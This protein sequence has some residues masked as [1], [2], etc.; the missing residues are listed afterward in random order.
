M[1]TG[2]P[3]CR[4]PRRLQ[5]LSSRSGCRK[6]TCDQDTETRN[7]NGQGHSKHEPLVTSS[8][9]H[10][11]STRQRHILTMPAACRVPRTL[12]P[13]RSRSGCIEDSCAPH[14][15]HTH[16][17]RGRHSITHTPK[18]S[19][20]HH[21]TYAIQAQHNNAYSQVLQFVESRDGSSLHARDLVVGKRPVPHTQ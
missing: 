19:S 20:P 8:H 5:R 16:T 13:S 12:Q 15:T 2:S 18:A 14:T 3:G 9:E 7:K 4:V 6:A 10:H 11:A 1:L 17:R 21:H